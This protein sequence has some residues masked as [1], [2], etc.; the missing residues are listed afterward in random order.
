MKRAFTYTE[1]VVLIA[2]IGLVSLVGANAHRWMWSQAQLWSYRQTIQEVAG[3]LRQM[4]A[5]AVNAQRAVTMRIDID[6]RRF[7]LVTVD[8]NPVT[9]ESVERTIW[10]PPG[11]DIRQAP[12]QLTASSTGAMPVTSIIIEAPAF[13]REFQL[14]TQP[15]GLVRLHE[16]PIT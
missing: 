6:A 4:R 5:R 1:T 12:D 3:T 9:Q 14:Q 15:S 16:E 2:S 10:L 7:Q 8:A 13:Q 11:L